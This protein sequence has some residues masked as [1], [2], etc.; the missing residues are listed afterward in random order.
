MYLLY[1]SC[2]INRNCSVTGWRG[3]CIL[4]RKG[5]LW[6]WPH[7]SATCS[8]SHWL[9]ASYTQGLRPGCCRLAKFN[10]VT[11]TWF[12][13][14]NNFLVTLSC[15]CSSGGYAICCCR[16]WSLKLWCPGPQV[17]LQWHLT[18]LS[19]AWHMWYKTFAGWWGMKDDG[20]SSSR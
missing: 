20:G 9:A 13:Q 15:Y 7:I 16:F 11:P 1:S 2:P 18:A 4:S 3:P 17:G 8:Y 5:P 12:S 19:S 14:S 10:I 6:A